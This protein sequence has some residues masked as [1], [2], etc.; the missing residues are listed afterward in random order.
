MA[1]QGRQGRVDTPV[2]FNHNLMLKDI[3]SSLKHL[4]REPENTN[5]TQQP[6]GVAHVTY[7][8]NNITNSQ[9]HH[10]NNHQA[11]FSQRNHFVEPNRGRHEHNI[12]GNRNY[13][14]SGYSSSSSECSSQ[15]A[16]D[17]NGQQYGANIEVCGIYCCFL[18]T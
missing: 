13:D 1:E 6:N 18:S 17:F 3:R 15:S 8:G 5:E 11:R 16:N 14:E 2:V 7:R 9:N 12:Q 10:V 4:R